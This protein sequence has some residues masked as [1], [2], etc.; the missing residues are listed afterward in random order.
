MF[1]PKQL[2]AE[3]YIGIASMM[4]LRLDRSNLT[5][6]EA[7]ELRDLSKRHRHCGKVKWGPSAKVAEEV[8]KLINIK[9][10]IDGRQPMEAAELKTAIR[11]YLSRT[12][13]DPMVYELNDALNNVREKRLGL[14]KF[15][16]YSPL[17]EST[18]QG[19]GKK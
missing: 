14:D 12:L 18:P 11:S 4:L 15:G 10:S 3:D 7:V 2:R 8:L 13:D 9:R 17:D 1:R 19:D 5:I 16:I 6:A